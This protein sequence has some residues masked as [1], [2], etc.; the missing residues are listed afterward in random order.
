MLKLLKDK[1]YKIVIATVFILLFAIKSISAQTSNFNFGVKG[2]LNLSTAIV[3]E[4]DSKFKQ[5][6][7]IGGTVDYLLAPK[8]E[9]QSGLFFSKTGSKIN[10]LNFYYLRGADLS[11]LPRPYST[12]TFNTS[13]LKLP[14]HIAFRKNI[15]D[16]FNFYTGFGFY[17]GYGI[18][19]KTKNWRRGG[20]IDCNENLEPIFIKEFKWDTFN[21]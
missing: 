4:G 11:K 10:D 5:G 2:G 19:G 1:G 12:H 6:Y 9:L 16:N 21:L 20:W 13:Y 14:L 18:G 15:S 17:F 3:S 8:F 7:N